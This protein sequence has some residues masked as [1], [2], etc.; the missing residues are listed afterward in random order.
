MIE[1]KLPKLKMIVMLD[2]LFQILHNKI[3]APGASAPSHPPIKPP[4]PLT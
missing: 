4:L 1:I 3:S 2:Y